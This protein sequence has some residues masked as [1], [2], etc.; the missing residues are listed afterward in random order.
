MADEGVL[1][2][3]LMRM[4][5]L[6]RENPNLNEEDVLALFEAENNK[7]SSPFVPRTEVPCPVP[8]SSVCNISCEYS[9][10]I[11]ANPLSDT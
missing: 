2:K 8:S 3:Q 5:R 7:E 9:V 4:A 11:F 6:Q 1:R 10:C